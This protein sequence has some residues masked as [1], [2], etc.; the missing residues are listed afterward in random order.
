MDEDQIAKL[1]DKM[2]EVYGDVEAQASGAADQ[3]SGQVQRAHRSSKGGKRKSADTIEAQLGSFVK[4]RPLAALL[5]AAGLGYALSRL[6][7]RR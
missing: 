4:E 1:G 6:T 2:K 3:A 5:A 7:G